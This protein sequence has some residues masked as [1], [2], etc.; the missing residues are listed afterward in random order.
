MNEA[1]TQYFLRV[2]SPMFF[3]GLLFAV[4]GIS[5]ACCNG[6]FMFDGIC[7][8]VGEALVEFY[9]AVMLAIVAPSDCYQHPIARWQP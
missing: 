7:N 2:A 6:V 8:V 3:I 4:Y 5:L 9:I 1:V